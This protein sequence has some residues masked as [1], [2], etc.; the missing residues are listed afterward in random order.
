MSP[1]SWGHV[2]RSLVGTV[3]GSDVRELEVRAGGI[4]IKLRR[5]F[6]RR[7]IPATREEDQPPDT[8]GL[9]C[10]AAR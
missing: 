6:E 10:C 3:E 8:S 5:D 4:R 9:T 2:L 1:V 7:V